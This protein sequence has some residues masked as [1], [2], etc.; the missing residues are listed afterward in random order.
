MSS[1]T[2]HDLVVLSDLHIGEGLIHDPPQYSPMEDF[3]HDQAFANLLENLHNRY[4]N[5]PSQL[6]L[7]FNGD[8]FDFLTVTRVPKPGDSME[9]GY[10]VS[11]AERKFGLNPTPAKSVYKLDAILNGHQLFFTALARFL[12]AGFRLEILRGNHDLEL[13]FP[14]VQEHLQNHLCNLSGGPTAAQAREQIRFHQWFYLEPGRLYIEHGNQYEASNSIRYPL[15][16][17]LPHKRDVILDYPL[18]SLFVRYFYNRVHHLDPYTPKMISFE[19]YVEF[20]RR[21]NLIDLLRIF[22]DHYSFFVSALQSDTTGGRS[23]SSFAEDA[24]QESAFL[25]ADA[26]VNVSGLHHN[27]NKLKNNPMSASK[28]ALFREMFFPVIKRLLRFSAI[29]FGSLYLWLLTF[30]VIQA[31]PWLVE[32]VFLKAVLLTLFAI[33]SLLLLIWGGNYSGQKLRYR[34]GETLTM[35]AVRAD[36]IARLTGVKLVLMGHTHVV[37]IRKVADGKATYANSGTWTSVANP[38]S[39]IFP[40]ARRLTFLYVRGN[41]VEICRWNDDALRIDLVPIFDSSES[42]LPGRDRLR[43]KTSRPKHPARRRRRSLKRPESNPR[44]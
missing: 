39:R 16:P 17:I 9:V 33:F 6:V 40:D 38:W 25:Q 30:N 36:P 15:S 37:D 27:L 20:I 11:R 1:D 35:G 42:M 34:P 43:S 10:R 24:K 13:F 19:Q 28:L 26:A 21:Y 4:R 8:V 44:Q 3:F 22:E 7:V 31:T 23:R 5:D 18:G 14:E 32:N 29:A 12:A 2:Q 41:R